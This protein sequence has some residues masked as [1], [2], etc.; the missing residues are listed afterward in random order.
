MNQSHSNSTPKI[1]GSIVIGA[2]LL[3]GV[4]TLLTSNSQSNLTN[5]VVMQSA[6][7]MNGMSS[8]SNSAV[9]NASSA[10]ETTQQSTAPA[11]ASSSSNTY[12]DGNYTKSV[13]YRVPGGG[14]N[15]LSVSISLASDS[16]DSV[17]ATGQ[18]LE[19][20]SSFYVNSFNSGISNAVKGKKLDSAFVGRVGGASYTSNAFNNIIDSIISDAK[21]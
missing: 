11:T 9:S 3:I 19:R 12:K 8:T 16:I 21:I 7:T 17:K 2:V 10:A 1:V 14:V 13:S 5:S 6:S 15:Q 18:Y 20:E 4:Y